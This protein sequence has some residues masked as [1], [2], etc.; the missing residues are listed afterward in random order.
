MSYS[1]TNTMKRTKSLR[2]TATKVEQEKDSKKE[3][4]KINVDDFDFYEKIGRNEFGYNRL[5]KNVESNKIYSMKILKKCD[6]LQ[7]KIVEHLKS[8][9]TILS[10]IYHPFIAE[11]KGVNTKNPTSLYFLF[12]FVQG[13]DL[14][15]LLDTKKQFPLEMAK[16]YAASI[17]TIFDY[18]HKKKIIYR[19]L[20]PE[21]ILLGT[22]GYIKLTNFSFAKIMK[23]D[24][25]NTFCGSPEYLAPEMI[26][27][28]GH[29]K[30]VDFWSLGILLYEMLVGITPFADTD[31]MKIYQKINRGKI[32][33]P[34]SFSKE[35]KILIKHLL[36]IDSKKRLG[37]KEKGI[38]EIINHPFFNG[39]DWKGLL[40]K[41]IE[42]PYIPTI[43]GPMDVSN[44]KKVNDNYFD[45]EDIPI[46]K[47][48]DP[49]YNWV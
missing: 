39:F 49:F 6:L 40:F 33:M 23:R 26:N 7:S 10:T 34:K 5:C 13:G 2:K 14:S 21:N 43:S 11:L 4:E 31:P 28:I 22:D 38:F 35:L 29:N 32:I 36:M 9:Y 16:F 47:E 30:G 24:T 3:I 45:E 17:L 8:E 46:E 18:L 27:K 42:A 20:R 19:N 12:E 37:M 41:N 15:T 25:T 1:K 44:Y 48:K